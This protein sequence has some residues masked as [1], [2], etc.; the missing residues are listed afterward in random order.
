[1][2]FQSKDVLEHVPVPYKSHD[3][4]VNNF[5]QN[6]KPVYIGGSMTSLEEQDSSED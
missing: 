4:P 1:M 2:L 5:L 6:Q 3:L